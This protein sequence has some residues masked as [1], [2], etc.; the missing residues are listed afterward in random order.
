MDAL[1]VETVEWALWVPKLLTALTFSHPEV[2]SS[3]ER[4]GMGQRQIGFAV[5]R[6]RS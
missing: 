6:T 1:K 2:S 5:R 4:M 3:R